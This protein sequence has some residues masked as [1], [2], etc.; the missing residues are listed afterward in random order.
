MFRVLLGLFT[1]AVL[2][3]PGGAYA[4][5]IYKCVDDKGALHVEQGVLPAWCASQYAPVV[6]D[7]PATPQELEGAKRYLEGQLAAEMAREEGCKAQHERIDE[8]KDDRLDDID[9]LSDNRRNGRVSR[10][11]ARAANRIEQSAA[12]LHNRA[13]QC[14]GQAQARAGELRAALADPV[15]ISAEVPEWRAAQQRIERERVAQQKVEQERRLAAVRAAE[16]RERAAEAKQRAA[17]E[18]AAEAQRRARAQREAEEERGRAIRRDLGAILD[19][20]AA[21]SRTI[22]DARETARVELAQMEREVDVLQRRYGMLLRAAE[23]REPVAALVEGV[24]ALREAGAALE[25]ETQ[26]ATSSAEVTARLQTMRTRMGS[27]GGTLVD[28]ANLDTLAREVDG[29]RAEHEKA[30]RVL[31]DRRGSLVRVVERTTRL[32][33]SLQ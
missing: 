18:A 4:Q 7:K 27:G 30:A 31:A 29:V 21:T 3:A 6:S 10:A 32:S 25:R 20:I 19:R 11:E 2:L 1:A 26:L 13:Q 5:R 22:I 24:L 9:A 12:S 16:E 17:E 8:A 33:A 15:K 28:R 14:V 23:Y